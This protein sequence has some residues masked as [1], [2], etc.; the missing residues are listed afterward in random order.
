MNGKSWGLLSVALLSFFAL[1]DTAAAKTWFL[2]DYMEKLP[3]TYRDRLNDADTPTL[4]ATECARFKDSAGNPLRAQSE[5]PSGQVCTRYPNAV[6]GKNC[7]GNCKCDTTKFIYDSSN[8]N[9][10]YVLAGSFCSDTTKRATQC[11]CNTRLFP[12]SYNGTTCRFPDESLGTC[13]DKKSGSHIVQQYYDGLHFKKCYADT[14]WKYTDLVEKGSAT[15]KWGC[16]SWVD[17]DCPKCKASTCYTD[18][19]HLYDDP[20]VSSCKYG[21]EE[22]SSTICTSKCAKCYEDNCR[23]RK[24]NSTELGCQK[25]W[26]DCPSKCETGKT[27]SPRDCRAEGYTQTT[28]PANANCGT[29]CT[30]PCDE[31]NTKY[32]KYGTC[33]TGYIDLLNYWCNG[34]VKCFWK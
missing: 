28:C 11:L 13:H 5:I 33:N 12:Y 25:Y 29:P 9:G 21:C 14:C 7:V 34:A 18:D 32:Y 16:P 27:C 2:P 15:C 20:P 30:D 19:C 6:I 1:T 24:D 22:T 3:N 4:A 17:P 31:N 10:N 8:C 23:N 26:A